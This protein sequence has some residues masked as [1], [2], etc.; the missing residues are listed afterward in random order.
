M[1]CEAYLSKTQL[2]LSMKELK[3]ITDFIA[4]YFPKYSLRTILSPEL[5]KL[6]R[7]DKK[8]EHP[9]EINFTLLKKIGKGS[10]NHICSETQI[11]AALNFYDSL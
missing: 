3:E 7:Q 6:M 10:I 5:I 4:Q 2:D 8:N 11:T 1:I 9:D